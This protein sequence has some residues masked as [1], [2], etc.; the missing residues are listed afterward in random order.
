[1]NAQNNAYKYNAITTNKNHKQ[2]KNINKYKLSRQK[3]CQKMIHKKKQQ[4]KHYTTYKQISCLF[5]QS[6]TSSNNQPI[7]S[8]IHLKQQIPILI[9]NA[10]AKHLK[11]KNVPRGTLLV[12]QN[13]TR[14]YIVHFR[15]I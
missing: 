1:M 13:N 14:L 7:K 12:L 2:Q 5:L 9:K 6:I 10:N 4:K 8:H 3:Q 11:T 15:L